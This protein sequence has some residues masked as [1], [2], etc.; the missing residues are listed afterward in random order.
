MEDVFWGGTRA[1]RQTRVNAHPSQPALNGSSSRAAP[2][3]SGRSPYILHVLLLQRPKSW[4]N[5]KSFHKDKS[6]KQPDR[7]TVP[8]C[9]SRAS[10][11]PPGRWSDTGW[12]PGGEGTLGE[13]QVGTWL[14]GL[15]F[16]SPRRRSRWA[17]KRGRLGGLTC[18]QH[19]ALFEFLL[20]TCGST[21][22]AGHS[23]NLCK[24]LAWQEHESHF[25]TEPA[26]SV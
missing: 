7:N 19:G 11:N 15:G 8:S 5:L 6:K 1:Q 22:P 3:T 26:S 16:K 21:H 10:T 13:G 4:C 25:L 2:L 18:F 24:A 12:S 23:V 14:W 9:P 20:R 17:P